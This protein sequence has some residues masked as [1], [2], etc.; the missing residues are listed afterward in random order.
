MENIS[1]REFKSRLDK[2]DPFVLIDVRTPA[3]F[4]ELHVTGAKNVP[5]AR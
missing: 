5:L 4:E 2:E 3:E 1:V